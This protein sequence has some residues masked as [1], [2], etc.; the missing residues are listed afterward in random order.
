MPAPFAVED[1]D[2]Q[3]GPARDLFRFLVPSAVATALFVGGVYWVR[4]Q[5]NAGTAGRDAPGVVQVHLLPR[6]NPVPVPPAPATQASTADP[7]NSDKLA[8]KSVPDASN[9]THPDQPD[10]VASF[11]PAAAKADL[12]QSAASNALQSTAIAQYRQALLRHIANYQRYP[13]A[14]ERE[15]LQGTVDT[16]FSMSRDGR[17]LGVWIKSSSGAAALDQAAIEI[18]RRAQP[19]PPIPAVLPDPLRIELALGF[20]PS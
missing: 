6:P 7:R 20:D 2:P 5:A 4:L 10:R 12:A 13:K 15:R 1:D 14:A 11:S 9:D 16:V 19:L 8:E 3:M 18:I 17:L